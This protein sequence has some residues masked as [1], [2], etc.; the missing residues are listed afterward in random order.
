M[1]YKC[2]LCGKEHEL[3]QSKIRNKQ[4]YIPP[5]GCSEGDYYDNLY[6]WFPCDCG[7][8]IKVIND[9]VIDVTKV[10]K[11]YTPHN[12]VSTIRLQPE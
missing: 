6:F 5:R 8:A 1:K 10:D 4:C 2:D 12:G 7:R 9:D 11:D 3:D